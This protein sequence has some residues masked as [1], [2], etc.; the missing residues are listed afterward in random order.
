[1]PLVHLNVDAAMLERIDDF[2]FDNR[3]TSHTAAITWLLDWALNQNPTPERP[4][5]H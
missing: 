2:R 3:F 4:N 5:P 1:M